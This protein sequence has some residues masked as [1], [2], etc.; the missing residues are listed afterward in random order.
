MISNSKL[1]L[2]KGKRR[3]TKGRGCR[4]MLTIAE[5]E[6]GGSENLNIWLKT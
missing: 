6:Q 2:G 3:M 5:E 1:A 4:Q